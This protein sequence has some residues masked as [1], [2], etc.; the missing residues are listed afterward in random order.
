MLTSF[1]VTSYVC[2]I[3]VEGLMSIIQHRRA[4]N[5]LG[6]PLCDN[7]RNGDW[8]MQYTA[9]RLL[10][11]PATTAVRLLYLILPTMD[12]SL[13]NLWTFYFENEWTDINVEW[14]KLA[15]LVHGTTAWNDQ[16]WGS[17][18]QR[19][20]SHKVEDGFGNLV[21]ASFL[22]FHSTADL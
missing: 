13:S 17:G 12:T 5:D 4:H 15:Q 18:C 8:L 22:P 10:A 19:S 16:L 14:Y 2:V 1:H 7:L 3:C 20:R 6:H 11:Y 9:N 21:E